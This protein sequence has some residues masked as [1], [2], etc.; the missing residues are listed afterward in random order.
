MQQLDNHRVL[1]AI[2]RYSVSFIA[3]KDLMIS[4]CGVKKE[5]E[6]ANVMQLYPLNVISACG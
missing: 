5:W 1:F 3:E 2:Y 6:G 4:E